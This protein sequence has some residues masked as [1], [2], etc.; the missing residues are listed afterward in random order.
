MHIIISNTY[1]NDAGAGLGADIE[2]EVVAAVTAAMNK[3]ESRIIEVEAIVDD[4]LQTYPGLD[5]QDTAERV[6]FAVAAFG[7]A[8]VWPEKP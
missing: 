4:L 6:A 8:A 5:W 7:S 1:N 3:A 2:A